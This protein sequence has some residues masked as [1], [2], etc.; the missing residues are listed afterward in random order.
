MINNFGYF[1]GTSAIHLLLP[2]T[3]LRS[4]RKTFGRLYQEIPVIESYRKLHLYNTILIAVKIQPSV[5]QIHPPSIASD[6]FRVDLRIKI[7]ESRCYLDYMQ[8]V[9]GDSRK[10]WQH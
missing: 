6:K 9:R 5:T 10:V 8:L 3:A 4:E 2:F 7:L 1:N